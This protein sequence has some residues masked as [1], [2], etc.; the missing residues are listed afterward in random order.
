MK[1]AKNS[2][3]QKTIKNNSKTK[4]INLKN[5]DRPLTELEYEKYYNRIKR[6]SQGL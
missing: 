5:K 3:S 2:N 6:L 1:D 4:I